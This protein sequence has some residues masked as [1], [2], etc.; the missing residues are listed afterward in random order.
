[1]VDRKR[2]RGGV[3][4]GTLMCGALAAGTLGGAPTANASCVSVFGIGNSANCTSNLGSI[5]IAIGT[6]A[7]ANATV[8]FGGAFAIGN[9]ASA[10][11]DN[12]DL[13]IQMGTGYATSEGLFD[14]AISSTPVKTADPLGPSTF[15]QAL[16]LGTLA[17]NLGGYGTGFIDHQVISAGIA[18]IAF[19][20]GGVDNFV[21]G[22]SGP[23]AIAASLEQTGQKVTK[24]RPGI[25]INNGLVIGGAAAVGNSR[26][27]SSA[28][29]ARH[30][31]TAPTA[32]A[33]H[34][35]KK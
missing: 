35:R 14:I 32:T 7:M 34:S 17:L 9:Y 23:F 10:N 5:A 6:N 31:A 29:A 16:G 4:L 13:A 26:K 18:S 25:N 28:T 27:K 24:I 20:R 12:F 11:A 33:A 19:D 2:T 15:V 21:R 3:V 8:F 30:H 1:M 22:G